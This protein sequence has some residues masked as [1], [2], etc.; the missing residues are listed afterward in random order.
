[1]FGCARMPIDMSTGHGCF[2]PTVPVMGSISTFTDQF[3]QVR[4]T[5]MWAPHCCGPVCHPVVSAMGSMTTFADQLPKMRMMDMLSCGDMV[6][7]G[8]LTTF[9]G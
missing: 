3:S 7:V 5:D 2:P 6:A 4:V 9:A 8:S 1:M